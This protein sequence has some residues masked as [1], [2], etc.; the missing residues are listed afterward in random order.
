MNGIYKLGVVVGILVIY[1][2][3]TFG[4]ATVVTA[5]E[6]DYGLTCFCA[7]LVGVLAFLMLAVFTLEKF[8]LWMG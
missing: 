2:L 4:I 8:G 6:E 1:V 7:W 3:A 5:T